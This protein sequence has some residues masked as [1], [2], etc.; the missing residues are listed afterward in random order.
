[1]GSNL[2]PIFCLTSTLPIKTKNQKPSTT[3]INAVRKNCQR[4]VVKGFDPDG[5]NFP[6]SQIL[7][8][9]P[10]VSIDSNVERFK[11]NDY[12][13]KVPI[14]ENYVEIDQKPHSCLKKSTSSVFF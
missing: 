10:L 5:V 12:W 14:F 6:S 8:R 7:T 1:M 3:Q 11:I 9:I 4:S 13:F 2:T